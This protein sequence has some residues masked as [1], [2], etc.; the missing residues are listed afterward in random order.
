MNAAT[1]GNHYQ[2]RE[3][4]GQLPATDWMPAR[5]REPARDRIEPLRARRDADARGGLRAADHGALRGGVVQAVRL[6]AS[7]YPGQVRR[8]YLDV[9][10]GGRTAIGRFSSSLRRRGQGR[11]CSRRSPGRRLGGP[12]PARP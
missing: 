5:F 8:R 10:S 7:P 9:P 6:S 11:R 2:R 12:Y 1:T 4:V 3:R